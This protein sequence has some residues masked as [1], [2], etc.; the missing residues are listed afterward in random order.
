MILSEIE[1]SRLKINEVE[2]LV[3]ITKKNI[4]FYEEA[5]LL[6]PLRD[7][8][9]GYRNYDGGDVAVLRQIKLLRKLGLPIEEIR[10]MQ[11]GRLTVSDAM[12]RHRV[13]LEREEHNLRQA[14]AL[15]ARLEQEAP[16]LDGL[17]TQALLEE[18]ER[19]EQEGTTFM[20]KQK[21]DTKARRYA[22]PVAIAALMAL[23]MGA[24]IWLFLWAFETDPQGAPPLPL[25]A[26][27]LAIPA[28]VILGVGIALI[29]RIREI[30]KGEEDDAR[31]Y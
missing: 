30:G 14:Q 3:G 9:N 11:S 17:D 1:V 29:Q 6:H 28:L 21:Q 19:L 15:C 10:R 4:R 2:A 13:T 18:M 27:F 12:R 22:A 16:A 26:L 24:L 5:G 23:L 8:A 20:N 31:K 25:L 7:S